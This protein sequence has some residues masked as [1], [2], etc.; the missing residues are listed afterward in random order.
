[1]QPKDLDAGTQPGSLFVAPD[2]Y[3]I[4]P[5]ATNPLPRPIRS[6]RANGAG[7]VHARTGGS[8]ETYR[9]LN[10]GAGETRFIVITHVHTDTTATG[11]EG[12]P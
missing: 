10:F 5:H 6:L 8:G 4:T 3:P 12:M 7:I 9:P 11:L 1:M 2:S